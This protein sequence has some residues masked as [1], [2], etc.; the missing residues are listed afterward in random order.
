MVG[1]SHST[2]G[3]VLVLRV[4]DP[5]SPYRITEHSSRSK[6][7]P[8][9]EQKKGNFVCPTLDFEAKKDKHGYTSVSLSYRGTEITKSPFHVREG[10]TRQE[11]VHLGPNL[12]VLSPLCFDRACQFTASSAWNLPT[13]SPT[14]SVAPSERSP[15]E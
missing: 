6:P 5:G 11:K 10:K 7:Y 4:V 2:A 14:L 1:W 13:L 8:K 15:V 12:S 9:T 3:K